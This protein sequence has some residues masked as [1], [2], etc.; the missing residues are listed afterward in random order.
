MEELVELED[1]QGII[2]KGYA[3]LEAATYLMLHL[4]NKDQAKSWLSDIAPMITSA[5]ASS[6]EMDTA[7]QIAFTSEGIK[8]LGFKDELPSFPLEFVEGMVT[9]HRQR[10]LGD[11][12]ESD[13]TYWK[14]GGPNE[15]KPIHV[16][17]MLFAINENAM[18][19]LYAVVKSKLEASNINILHKLDTE[20]LPDLKEHFGFRDGIGQPI[21]K[22]AQRNE[23]KHEAN[24]INP[25]EFLFGYKNEYDKYTFSPIVAP[26]KDPN[27]I[28][29]ADKNNPL[30]KDLG[31]NGSMLVFRQ[32]H[33]DVKKFW[34]FMYET[35]EKKSETESTTPEFVA[36]K[37]LGRW[38]NGAPLTKCPVAPD[39]KYIGY[40]NFGYAQ[41]DYDGFKC[42]VGAHIRRANPRDNFLRNSTGNAN[43][44]AEK[45][46][47]FM[48]RFRI[49]RRG[50]PF[51][52]PLAPSMSPPDM[53]QS[54]IEDT[55]RGMYFICFNSNIA[56]QFELIAQTWINNPK[57]AG[58]YEDPDPITG[59]PGIL[60][61]PS[62]A[63]FTEQAY[64]VRKKVSGLPRFIWAKGGAYFFMP[65]IKG[66]KF[67]GS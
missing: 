13:P 9:E 15:P 20:N 58:L 12:D 47:M 1:V 65:G 46:M 6:K 32:L 39:D 53:L 52:K 33:Q 56:R 48:K 57:F 24:N 40:D 3:R 8:A 64:P 17:L 55:N 18:D 5:Q 19:I 67:L 14:W 2:M 29:P 22:Y 41:Q 36:S 26:E 44:D 11:F 60:P 23:A 27:G 49:I 63:T 54:T 25:G 43:K 21:M 16:L 31:R 50:R 34:N 30:L 59:Y 62:S 61:D 38:L 42:P 66:L 37:M 10:V 35:A 7:I 51:G 4:N 28:L 45:S